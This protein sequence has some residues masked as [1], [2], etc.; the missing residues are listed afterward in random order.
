[1]VVNAQLPDSFWDSHI[2]LTSTIIF[3]AVVIYVFSQ[4]KSSARVSPGKVGIETSNLAD[5]FK[6][7]P[8]GTHSPWR[9]KSLW[10]FPL[11]S[12]RGIEVDQ[13]EVHKT[14]CAIHGNSASPFT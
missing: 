14:G 2:P 10:I 4:H 3:A 8:K 7:T 12:A 5:E 11:K 13:I 6:Y 9:V 1:M